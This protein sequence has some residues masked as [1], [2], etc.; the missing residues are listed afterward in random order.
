LQTGI[1]PSASL[2]VVSYEESLFE[3]KNY[4]SRRSG[5][6]GFKSTPVVAF[7]GAGRKVELVR[8]AIGIF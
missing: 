7:L 3:S 1:A 8:I 4:H 2:G 6:G 5:K